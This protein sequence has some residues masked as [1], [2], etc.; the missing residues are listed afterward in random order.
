MPLLSTSLSTSETAGLS[1][2]KGSIVILSNDAIDIL[3]TF[4]GEQLQKHAANVYV[5]G[6]QSCVQDIVE[7]YRY[8]YRTNGISYIKW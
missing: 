2:P 7:K 5:C 4:K 8:M 1:I 6:T 3:D